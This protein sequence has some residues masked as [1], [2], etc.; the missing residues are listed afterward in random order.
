MA[1]NDTPL[2]MNWEQKKEK[3]KELHQFLSAWGISRSDAQSIYSIAYGDIREMSAEQFINL[4]REMAA[5]VN[6]MK[7]AQPQGKLL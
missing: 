7:A 5:F 4:G 1:Y 6:M 3:V 2:R